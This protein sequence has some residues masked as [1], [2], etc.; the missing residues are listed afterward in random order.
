MS[1]KKD[2]PESW[3]I[4]KIGSLGKVITGKTPSTKVMEYWDKL[5]VP[6]ITPGSIDE[7][8]YVNNFLRY[9]SEKG[10]QTGRIL[11]R[12]TILTVCIGSTV[13]K[14]ALVSNRCIT[15]Q[16]INAVICNK[17][18]DPIFLYYAILYRA[19]YLKQLAGVAAVPIVKKSLFE[20]F[21]VFL[22]P[23]HGEQIKIGE[24]LSNIDI[25]I[26]QTQQLIDQ[27]QLLKKGLM[28]RFFTEGIGHTE[29]KE[30][31]LGFIPKE[32]DIIKIQKLI[33]DRIILKLQDGNHGSLYPRKHHF[34]SPGLHYISANQID[35]KGSVQIEKA[36]LISHD[37]IKVLQKGFGEPG[38]IILAHNATVGRV[39]LIPDNGPKY[40]ASTSITMYRI[41]RELLNR[42]FVFYFMQSNIFQRQ[43]KR[44]MPQS[45]RN[46]VPITAQKNLY[47]LIPK[48]PLEQQKIAAILSNVDGIIQSND[49]HLFEL[50]RVKKGL[51]QQ[52]LTGK[53]RAHIN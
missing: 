22:P 38:D 46:Q 41:N 19:K 21:R 49:K 51:M 14:V 5:D 50:K 23:S 27:L 39:G 40:I 37:Y 35:E 28:Q 18:I 29:F 33:E 36:S 11:Q 26:Y 2:I 20:N 1:L 32:W 15:N 24:I 34:Y 44:I 53:K 10:A 25:I 12:N 13:G 9:V 42:D 48:V 45:T 17:N 3:K 6:F 4:E 47:F 16:Q 8:L 31:R 43:L 7:N 30:T 52:L